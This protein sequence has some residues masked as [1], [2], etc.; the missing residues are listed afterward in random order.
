MPNW[1]AE[2]RVLWFNGQVVKR[3]KW[4]A[5][6]Q[7]AILAAFDEE[8]WPCRIDDPLPP[9][10]EQDPKRRLSDTIKCLNR[11]HFNRL[12]RFRGDGTGTGIVWELVNLDSEAHGAGQAPSP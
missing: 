2:K 9:H 4:H 10:P 6:N 5:V 12:I 3:F 1:G 7:E 11:K 8:G